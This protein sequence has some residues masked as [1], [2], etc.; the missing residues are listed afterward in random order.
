MFDIHTIYPAHDVADAIRALVENPTARVIAGG[1]DLLLRI[2]E[3]K[4]AHCALVSIHGLP[5]LSG[6][7][8]TDPGDLIIGALTTFR[9][10]TEDPQ[11]QTHLSMLAGAASD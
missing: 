8:Q 9:Q 3:G 5:E 4:L 11:I 2:R 10:L 7:R 1:T 6:I